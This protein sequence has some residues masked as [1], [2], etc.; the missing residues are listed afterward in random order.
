MMTLD[1]MLLQIDMEL[2][3]QRAKQKGRRKADL[4]L[5]KENK[6]AEMELREEALY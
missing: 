6:R 5:E 1:R 3:A 4:E 2:A